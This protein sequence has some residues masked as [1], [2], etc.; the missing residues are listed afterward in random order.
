MTINNVG[1]AEGASLPFET[2]ES[3]D[4]KPSPGEGKFLGEPKNLDTFP[5]SKYVE[6]RFM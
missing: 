1:W 5:E 6:N 2:W 3:R 4:Q